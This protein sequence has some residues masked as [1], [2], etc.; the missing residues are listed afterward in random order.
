MRLCRLRSKWDEYDVDIIYVKGKDNESADSLS[1]CPV[2]KEN[3]ENI[4]EVDMTHKVRERYQKRAAKFIRLYSVTEDSV[5]PNRNVKILQNGICCINKVETVPDKISVKEV[6]DETEKDETLQLIKTLITE[7][8]YQIEAWKPLNDLQYTRMRKKLSIRDN[9][10][11]MDG[12]LVFP[13]SLHQR[14]LKLL[15]SGHPGESCM[16]RREEN[17]IYWSNISKDITRVKREC[18]Y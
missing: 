12:R 11:M 6:V 2:G 7:E 8:N 1:R 18:E 9:M 13:K 14:V 17:T 16:Q 5:T 10:I 15:H 4:L 3:N